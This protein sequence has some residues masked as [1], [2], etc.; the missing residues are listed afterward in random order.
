MKRLNFCFLLFV[1]AFQ[2]MLA[3]ENYYDVVINGIYY[4][5]NKD[6]KEATVVMGCTSSSPFF[7]GMG[8]V[9]S[10]KGDVSI[11]E[12]FVYDGTTFKVT[13]IEGQKRDLDDF[14]S[15]GAFEGCSELTSIT[16]P[17]SIKSIGHQAFAGCTSLKSV[18]ISDLY[19]WCNVDF[20]LYDRYGYYFPNAN[21]LYFA[22]TLYLNGNKVTDLKIPDGIESIKEGS[23]I[24]CD[25]STVTFHKNTT[26]VGYKAFDECNYLY[27]VYCYS[28][29]IETEE[30]FVSHDSKTLH[31]R[32]RYNNNYIDEHDSY[33]REWLK[34]GKKEYIEGVDFLLKYYVDGV[35]YKETIIEVGEV[36]VPEPAPSKEG[37]TFSGWYDIPETMPDH[38]VNVTGAFSPNTYKLTYFVDGELYKVVEV[39]CDE[40]V[41]SE[42]Y[43]EKEGFTFSGWS[44]IPATMP[45]NDV[46]VYGTFSVNKYKLTFLVD[47]VE[48]V[49]YNIDYGSATRIPESI[50][51]KENY[52][53]I[54]WSEVPETMPARD[55]TSRASFK[56]VS[57]DIDGI[58]YKFVG[59]EAYVISN[60]K[61]GVVKVLSSFEEDDKSYTVTV[62]EK[63]AFKNNTNITS[64]E[65][66]N[67]IVAIND[68]AFFG[69]RNLTNIYLGNSVRVVGKRAFANID[70]LTDV[71]CYAEDVPETD[72]TVFENSYIDYVT[73]HVPAGCVEEYKATGPWKGFKEIVP[74]EG[75]GPTKIA[76][77][78]SVESQKATYNL[79]GIKVTKANKAAKG[80]VVRDG[81]KYYIR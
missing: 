81:K 55:I 20:D 57:T 60:N 47:D 77:I 1:F 52:E 31:V 18:N 23:F 62:I 36:I 3:N 70:K 64:V 13:S 41:D 32:K 39:K 12:S 54:S 63:N 6:L 19:A 26:N 44:E 67:T 76:H 37:Y 4:R 68:S 5:L 38:D 25:I 30:S 56:K 22:H 46:N 80:I 15:F 74:I 45:A 27:D 29:R 53:F 24:G 78:L 14:F 34:F 10:Y 79:N 71:V 33:S 17:K 8:F 65:I 40:S 42:P 43:P 28:P 2:T 9:A 75:E 58:K 66:P 35:Y 61:S 59:D 16:I 7:H 21:P 49:S 69:C 11:P 50:P 72:R 48:Y 73:L 51:Q